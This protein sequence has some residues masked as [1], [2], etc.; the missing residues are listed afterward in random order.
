[1]LLVFHILTALVSLI[2]TTYLV[3]TPSKKGLTAGYILAIA[4]IMSG[5]YLI[6][7]S[8]N[9]WQYCLSGISYIVL[10]LVGLAFANKRLT[11]KV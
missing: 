11:V 7:S 2:Y 9:P 3:I 1:M 4:T 5:T 10:A 6:L 8:A